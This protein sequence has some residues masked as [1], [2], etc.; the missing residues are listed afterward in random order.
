M[1]SDTFAF[2]SVRVV[3]VEGAHALEHRMDPRA[4]LQTFGSEAILQVLIRRLFDSKREVMKHTLGL[5][6]RKLGGAEWMRDEHDHLGH[7]ITAI[8]GAQELVGQARRRNHL[9]TEEVAVEMQGRVHV[10]HPEHDLGETGDRTLQAATASLI[11][12][13]LISRTRGA[14]DQ[15]GATSSPRPPVSAIA[16]FPS[17]CTSAGGPYRTLLP[18]PPPTINTPPLTLTP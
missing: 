13:R 10:A 7:S 3:D 2:V 5:L 14:T 11:A 6:A 4:L 15:P 12:T 17:A 1:G 9:E 8:P 18:F 16:R